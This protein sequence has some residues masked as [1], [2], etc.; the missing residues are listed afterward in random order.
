[1][2]I[3]ILLLVLTQLSTKP[4]LQ[5]TEIF[6]NWSSAIETT[7]KQSTPQCDTVVGAENGDTSF[8]IRQK[9]QLTAAFFD[10]I[11]PNLNCDALSVGQWVWVD[12][13]AN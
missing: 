9:F 2:T 4:A 12:G 7:A 8:D 5:N 1:M 11:N 3:F 13:T 10:S 6:S